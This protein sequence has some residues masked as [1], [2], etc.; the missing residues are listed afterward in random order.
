MSISGIHLR[1]ASAERDLEEVMQIEWNSF[2]D[3]DAFPYRE[4]TALMTR[5]A[6][7][8]LIA[9]YDGAIAGYLSFT[10][11]RRHNTGRVYSLAV[12]P[13]YRGLGV[14]DALMERAIACAQEKGLR[15]VFLEVRTDNFTAIRLYEK[16][17]FTRRFTKQSYYSDGNPA[18]YMA[19]TI[20]E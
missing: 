9:E 1:E 20:S 3:W 4:M 8:F 16:K 2:N 12:A 15:A 17:G 10:I 19:R 13:A 6:G 14:A 7:L 5:A 11:C 18:Y